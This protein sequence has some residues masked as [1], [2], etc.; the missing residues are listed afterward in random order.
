MST[1]QPAAEIDLNSIRL[2][3][4]ALPRNVGI[5]TGNGALAATPETRARRRT[6]SSC[7]TGLPAFPRRFRASLQHFRI[8]ARRGRAP[9]PM[10][11][12][13]R[14]SLDSS[15]TTLGNSK[16]RPRG[17]C[18]ATALMELPSHF[19]AAH[20][21]SPGGSPLLDRAAVSDTHANR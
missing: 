19:D 20:Q 6:A 2:A 8:S 10:M 17:Q 14:K 3:E 18:R 7:V 12:R 9:R 13:P 1:R 21:V 15:S 11:Q 5:L 16:L 4:Q